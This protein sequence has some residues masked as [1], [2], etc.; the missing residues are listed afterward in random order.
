MAGGRYTI[1]APGTGAM[2]QTRRIA[3]N[4][5]KTI[6]PMKERNANQ[7]MPQVRKHQGAQ[8]Q[9]DWVFPFGI[10]VRQL[11]PGAY[12]VPVFAG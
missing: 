2:D 8:G 12:H 10:H 6:L 11:G 5:P 3:G 9:K 4:M 7:H 1:N